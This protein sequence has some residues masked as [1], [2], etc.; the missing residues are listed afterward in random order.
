MRQAFRAAPFTW[1]AIGLCCVVFACLA[2]T[3]EARADR[4]DPAMAEKGKVTYERYCVSCHGPQ[5]RADGPLARD[6]AV[7]VPDLTTLAARN[8]GA[9]PYARVKEIVTHGETLRGHGSEDMPAWGDAFK[10]TTGIAAPSVDEAIANLA[11]YMW[12]L[13][14]K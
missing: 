9:Y 6:L 4:P 12:S 1:C 5:G 14:K 8:G 13:Q 2:V 7:A 3:P 11:H 10:K